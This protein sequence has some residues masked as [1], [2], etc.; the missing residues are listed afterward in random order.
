M[1]SDALRAV[2]VGTGGMGRGWLRSILAYDEVELVGVADLDVD[3]ARAALAEVGAPD[4][5]A[6][7]PTVEQVVD[8]VRP[9]FVVDV[10]IPEAHH[11]ITIAALSRG[12]PVLGE[13]PLAATLAEAVDLVAASAAYDR[14]FMVSQNRRYHAELFAL[15]HQ[16]AQLGRLGIVVSDFFKAPHFGGFRDEMAHPLVLDMAIHTFDSARFIIGAEPVSVS[17]EEYNPPWSWY[18]GDAGA[19]AT[20]AFA[21]GTRYVY[22]GSWCSPG[23]ETSWNASW[24]VSG[25]YGSAAWDGD[26]PP[27]FDVPEP[28]GE[29]VEAGAGGASG[30]VGAASAGAGGGRSAGP[31]QPPGAG[32]DG[33]LRDFVAALRNGS[34]PMGECRDNLMSLA[35]VHAAIESARTGAWV[36]LADVLAAARKQ[37]LDN[38]TGPIRDALT[39]ESLESVA[40]KWVREPVAGH[41][42]RQDQL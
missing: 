38:A 27:S 34:T 22:T 19:T 26:G 18:S 3:T 25:E 17:C 11:P 14:L 24:R 42:A 32:I 40:R 31:L 30:A 21:D 35:M 36:Q 15:R 10:A 16:L 7:E 33:S 41:R 8:N 37:A 6:V 13:K 12:I 29:A 1:S 9:D 20:F 39:A 2:V 5:I 4:G 23:M 28:A